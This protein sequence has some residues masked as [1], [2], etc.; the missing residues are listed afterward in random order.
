M[1]VHPV[2]YV[3]IVPDEPD[4]VL[5]RIEVEIF[6]MD[7]PQENLIHDVCPDTDSIDVIDTPSKLAALRA[8]WESVLQHQVVV[9][10]ST[11]ANYAVL[12]GSGMGTLTSCDACDLAFYFRCERNFAIDPAVM[13]R[14]SIK[15]YIRYRDD[16]F[17]IAKSSRE[18]EIWLSGIKSLLNG[19]WN[20]T[21]EQVSKFEDHGDNFGISH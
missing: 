2:L 8:A 11:G 17:V 10:K 3:G 21:V 15:L 20:L 5:I 18:S 9:D 13:R 12:T 16:I 14:H 1:P 7:P 4:D 19:T 6:F